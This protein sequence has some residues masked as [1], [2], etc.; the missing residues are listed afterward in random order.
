MMANR[1]LEYE[2][3]QSADGTW[4][5]SSL[6]STQSLQKRAESAFN[7]AT[8]WIAEHPELALAGAVV[9]GVVLGWLIKR[10]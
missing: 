7:Q 3:A 10:R 8:H 1:L 9:T 6:P 4:S 2:Q 5:L